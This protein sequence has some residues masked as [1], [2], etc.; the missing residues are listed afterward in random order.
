MRAAIFDMDG[1]LADVRSI[2]HFVN[3]PVRNFDAFHRASVNVPANQW[4]VKRAQALHA[5]G[6]AILVVT[7]RVHRFRNH[8][9]WWLAM[10]DVPSDGLWMRNDDDQRPDFFVKA[11]ILKRILDLGYTPIRA[12]DDNPAVIKL[13]QSHGIPTTIVPGWEAS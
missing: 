3:G 9:A 2:R 11:D 8:T 1:T 10:H 4:V 12:F 13:W 7:A 6:V 5:S